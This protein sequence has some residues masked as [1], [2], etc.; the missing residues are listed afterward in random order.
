MSPA[1]GT[2]H[3]IR[4]RWSLPRG[5]LAVHLDAYSRSAPLVPT[6]HFLCA[7]RRTL[8]SASS[9]CSTS[10]DR[11]DQAAERH[12]PKHALGGLKIDQ[13]GASRLE[14]RLEDLCRRAFAVDPERAACPA[15]SRDFGQTDPV[16]TRAAW[17]VRTRPLPR[18]AS[19]GR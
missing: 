12:R 18:P 11:V 6:F 1:A 2:D 15:V 8:W 14:P 13:G 7:M 4:T 10:Q 19:T 16:V 5:S 9:S 17:S 3:S